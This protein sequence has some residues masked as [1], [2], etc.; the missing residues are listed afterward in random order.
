V[1]LDQA[2]IIARW[3][4][5]TA[6]SH[7]ACLLSTHSSQALRIC[8]AALEEGLDLTHVTISGGGEPP[9]AAKVKTITRSG[10]RWVPKY[11]TV[12]AG[13]VGMGCAQ[14]LDEND[15]HFLRDALALIQYPRSVAGSEITVQAFH[16]TSLLPAAPKLLLNVESDD[17]GIVETRSCGCPFEALGYTEHLRKV[18]SFRKLTGEGVTLVGSDMLYILEEVLPER[19]G[20]SPL[21]YQIL[22]EE[23]QQGFTRLSLLI[24]PAIQI[25]D[26]AAIIKMVV[27]NLR[28]KVGQHQALDLWKQAQTLR[29]RRQKPILTARGKF[30]PLLKSKWS[31][32]E[33]Q[34]DA[35]K[36]ETN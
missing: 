36:K 34:E 25:E 21:D 22:E 15:M 19:F 13:P 10:A 7:G 12:E 18:E 23:D 5:K 8:M 3:A 30:V 1:N 9:S 28:R 20:G 24:N 17:Y 35:F 32:R 14:P 26:E 31:T 2:A 16:F 11:I 33:T 27:D 29:V 6:A 4:A